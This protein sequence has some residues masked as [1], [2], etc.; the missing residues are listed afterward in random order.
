MGRKNIKERSKKN[1]NGDCVATASLRGIRISPQKVRLELDMIRGQQ[2]EPAMRALQH[3]PRKGARIVLKLL[4]SAVANA[5]EHGDADVDNL[6]V[7]GAWA[8]M[9]RTLKRFLP[10]ARGM[11]TPIRKTSSHITVCLGEK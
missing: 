9:G 10:R 11:A 4:K 6:W 7:T 5:R 8:G 1:M 3:S 2:V